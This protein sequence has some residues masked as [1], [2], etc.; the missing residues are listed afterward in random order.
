MAW[1]KITVTAGQDRMIACHSHL[2]GRVWSDQSNQSKRNQ[3]GVL[4]PEQGTL[5]SIQSHK[6]Y[7]TSSLGLSGLFKSL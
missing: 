6:A 7:F 4:T 2:I 3:R 5:K 1:Y